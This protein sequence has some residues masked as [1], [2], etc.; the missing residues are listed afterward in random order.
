MVSGPKGHF[1]LRDSNII[2]LLPESKT[3]VFILIFVKKTFKAFLRQNIPVDV[4][5]G[6]FDVFTLITVLA[7]RPGGGANSMKG[8]ISELSVDFVKYKNLL[9]LHKNLDNL[10]VCNID[11]NIDA[12]G[13]MTQT[14]LKKN[15]LL[16]KC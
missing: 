10:I 3:A 12:R 5:Q 2:S 1:A 7:K 6:L 15:F 16:L 4:F 13:F 8:P 9:K 14:K 11:P